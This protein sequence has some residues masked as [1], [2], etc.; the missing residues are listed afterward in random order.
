MIVQQGLCPSRGKFDRVLVDAPCTGTGTWR[1]RPDTK[2][3][4]TARNLEERVQQQGE[5]LSQAKGFVRPGG[6][7]LYVT[8]SVLP[9]ENEQQVRRRFCEENP[10]FVIGSALERWRASF[11]CK[12][13][14]T[15]FLRRKDSD[16]DACNHRYG[17]FL[18]LLDE[19]QS[20]K[21]DLHAVILLA[22]Y[23]PS[24]FQSILN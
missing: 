13:E 11:R 17:R 8:C 23:R 16:A 20:I 7:L 9:E 21:A 19:A 3:R 24:L 4:L 10:E 14:Q 2:W 5:A 15:A 22:K 6:E 18:L 12:C 1:R